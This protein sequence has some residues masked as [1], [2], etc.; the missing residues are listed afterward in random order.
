M[1]FLYNQLD[2]TTEEMELVIVDDCYSTSMVR[3]ALAQPIF[4]LNVSKLR[5]YFSSNQVMK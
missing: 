1:V 4:K 5:G 2:I 3:K